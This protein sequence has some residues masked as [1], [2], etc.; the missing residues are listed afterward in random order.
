MYRSV[1]SKQ[2]VFKNNTL[3]M[4]LDKNMFRQHITNLN[5]VCYTH[6][7]KNFGD[8]KTLCVYQHLM[9][10]KRCSIITIKLSVNLAKTLVSN[11]SQQIKERKCERNDQHC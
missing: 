6:A 1:N 2:N 8:A 4:S 9:Y 3:Q 11:V 7:Q 10:P 5:T